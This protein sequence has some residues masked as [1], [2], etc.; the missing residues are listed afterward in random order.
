MK[1]NKTIKIDKV[2]RISIPKPIRDNLNI[3]DGD[4]LSILSDSG[5][6]MLEKYD[7]NKSTLSDAATEIIKGLLLSGAYVHKQTLDDLMTIAEGG[8]TKNV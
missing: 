2:G 6:I 4:V 1:S 7:N 3:C 5:V 8:N